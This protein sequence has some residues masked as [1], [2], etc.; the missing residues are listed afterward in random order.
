MRKFLI[1]RW[2]NIEHQSLE[3]KESMMAHFENLLVE[4]YQMLSKKLYLIRFYDV[5]GG[6]K[7]LICLKVRF[8]KEGYD[9]KAI[10][11]EIRE[12]L[13]REVYKNMKVLDFLSESNRIKNEI[14]L[15]I[16]FLNRKNTLKSIKIYPENRSLTTKQTI[17]Y[18]LPNAGFNIILAIMVNFTLFFY[19]NLMGQPPIIIGIILSL[20]LVIY[21][22]MCAFWGSMADKVGINKILWFGSIFLAISSILYWTPPISNLGYG[23][24]YLP[25]ILWFLCFSLLFRV[26]GAAFQASIYSL[27]PYL[28][29]NEQDRIKISLINMLMLTAGSII[30]VMVPLIMLGEA[31]KNLK[32]DNPLLYFPDSS[33]GKLIYLQVS[34]FSIILS[35]IF[36]TFLFLMQFKFR[37]GINKINRDF[38]QE[39]IKKDSTAPFRDKNYR[40]WLI[41][42]FLF[43]IPFV[44]F[45]Y[46][47]LNIATYMLKL[48]GHEFMLLAGGALI[49]VFLSFPLWQRITKKCG[50]KKTFVICLFSGSILFLLTI[51]LI[52][53]FHHDLI[54]WFGLVIVCLIICDLIGI[55]GLPL[56]IVSKFVD[57]AKQ[58]SA[59]PISGVY[60]GV[61]IMFGSFSAAFSML[62]ASAILQ[63]FGPENPVSY[64]LIFLIGAGTIA[65]ALKIFVNI[66]F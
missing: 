17:I 65:I 24:M 27:I 42:F 9:F 12:K 2:K 11:S 18:C 64:I 6:D 50:I 36:L 66:Q 37:K 19:I 20:S 46:L 61:F 58:T 15:C 8:E 49:S 62:F 1:L 53:P 14:E 23:E 16:E 26:A 29:K 47:I 55:M 33:I 13:F 51:I 43:W 44:A 41:A 10:K 5:S 21:A 52:L 30:G 25:L 40:K 22:I 35:I 56:A 28:S 4:I 45:Q 7:K 34:I 38:V 60:T 31:T 59:N 57:K 54:L 32:R 48:R 39:N 3:Y 63:I